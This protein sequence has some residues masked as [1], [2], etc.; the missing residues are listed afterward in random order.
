M[1]F[2][3]RYADFFFLTTLE[4]LAWASVRFP[5]FL[6]RKEEGRRKKEEGRRKGGREGEGKGDKYKDRSK[7]EEWGREGCSSASK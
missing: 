2:P 1:D 4:N 7:K 5:V 6:E 3:S